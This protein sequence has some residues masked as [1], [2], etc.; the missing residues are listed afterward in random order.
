MHG[1][2]LHHVVLVE[3]MKAGLKGNCVQSTQHNPKG[4]SRQSQQVNQADKEQEQIQGHT[5]TGWTEEAIYHKK[6]TSLY[7]E[8]QVE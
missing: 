4:C 7:T 6:W 8:A 1:G 3:I 2:Q 5:K